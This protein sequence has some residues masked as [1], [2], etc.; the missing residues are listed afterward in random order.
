MAGEKALV[1]HHGDRSSIVRVM[2]LAGLLT[3]NNEGTHDDGVQHTNMFL[4]DCD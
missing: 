3:M 2:F 4:M 1:H